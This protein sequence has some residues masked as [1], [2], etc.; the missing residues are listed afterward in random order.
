[1]FKGCEKRIKFILFA[2]TLLAIIQVCFMAREAWYSTIDLTSDYLLEHVMVKQDIPFVSKAFAKDRPPVP[3][4]S[5]PT[6]QMI[7]SKFAT[8]FGER[9]GHEAVA[10]S[11]AENGSRKCD[12]FGQNTNGTRDWGIFQI[13]EI[14]QKRWT[15]TQMIGCES[16]IDIAVQIYSEQGWNPWVA[17]K[18][19]NWKK[20]PQLQIKLGKI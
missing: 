5:D 16:N 20:Y 19:G 18:N 4:Y 9:V 17:Y 15:V 8:R 10:V 1:M 2:F 14:H 3:E 13:N 7:Y 11:W 12:R 6:E